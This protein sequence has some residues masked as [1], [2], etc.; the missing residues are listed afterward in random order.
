MTSSGVTVSGWLE[1]ADPAIPAA[2]VVHLEGALGGKDQPAP[3]LEGLEGA[4]LEELG[5]ALHRPGRDR[6]A[7]VHL[8][9]ADGLLTSACALAAEAP[10]VGEA[11]GRL[12]MAFDRP[13]DP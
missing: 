11:L 8:L 2:L 12:L 5:E 6:Q 1:E 13:R 3:D 10:S 7:A 4:A 9:A